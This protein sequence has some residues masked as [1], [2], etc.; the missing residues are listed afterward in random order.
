MKYIDDTL[1]DRP[2]TW[3]QKVSFHFW[4]IEWI[5]KM[6]STKF[7]LEVWWY[8]ISHSFIIYQ[9]PTLIGVSLHSFFTYWRKR[10]WIMKSTYISLPQMFCMKAI[11]CL[12]HIMGLWTV[13]VC[14]TVTNHHYIY[15]RHSRQKRKRYQY[16][17]KT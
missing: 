3:K 5:S 12:L 11:F 7:Y 13:F 10:F 4:T 8:C 2:W 14:L 17:Y 15:I 9:C 16:S 6:C 1:I